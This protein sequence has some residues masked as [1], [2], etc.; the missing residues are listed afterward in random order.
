MFIFG[1][2]FVF[3]K[4][5]QYIEHIWSCEEYRICRSREALSNEYLVAKFGFDTPEYES[6]KVCQKVVR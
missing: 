5:K 1:K 6:A 4:K 3:F 2:M